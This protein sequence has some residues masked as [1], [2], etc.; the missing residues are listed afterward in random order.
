MNAAS[1]GSEKGRARTRLSRLFTD[2][3]ALEALLLSAALVA[4]AWFGFRYGGQVFGTDTLMYLDR[5]LRGVPDPFILN[6]YS[7]VFLLAILNA[8]GGTALGGMRLLSAIAFVASILLVYLIA[9]RLS[10]RSTPLNGAFAAFLLVGTPLIVERMIAPLVDTTA[11]LMMLAITG[12]YVYSVRQDHSRRWAVFAL[13]LCLFAG[14]R[15][16]ETLASASVLIV[17]LGLNSEGDFSAVR[18]R[19]GLKYLS[20]GALAGAVVNVCANSLVLHSPLFGFRPGD[21]A[22]YRELWADTIA[23]VE[24][25]GQTFGPFVLGE[26]GLVFLLFAF[27]GVTAIRQTDYRL[28]L[29]WLVPLALLAIIILFSPRAGWV[30]T[31]RGYLPGLGVM[32]VLAS[33][34]IGLDGLSRWRQSTA[35]TVGLGF[36]GIL[37][38]LAAL[39]LTAESEMSFQATF[40][41]ALL[42]IVLLGGLGAVILTVEASSRRGFAAV[43]LLPLAMMSA[44]LTV[45]QIVVYPESVNFNSRFLPLGAFGGQIDRAGALAI[46][47]SSDILPVMGIDENRDELAALVNA[48]LNSTT[49]RTD[50]SIGDIDESLLADLEQRL[51]TYVLVTAEEWDWMRT[52]PQD[53]PEWRSHYTASTDPTGRFVLLRLNG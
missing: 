39:R 43:V 3:G 23:T 28:R 27:A 45:R 15:T 1:Y 22:T 32:C 37:A 52:A 38:V 7:H 9:S 44:A 40:E 12:L 48:G 47:V 31:P 21:I 46:H 30:I 6:R 34:V 4:G 51:H 33:Q 17:G 24:S 42:P 25:T 19:G 35:A 29:V 20:L 36:T 18:L 41:A 14:F 8:L 13:G 11:M 2:G 49:L 53:R 16:K 5:A 26:H 50:Y 10:D